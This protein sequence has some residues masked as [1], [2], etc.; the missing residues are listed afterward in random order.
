MAEFEVVRS[1]SIEAPPTRIHGLIADLRAW[2]S[3][4]PWE[5]H[6]P[7]LRRS[8]SGAESGVGAR[9]AWE[10]NRRAG[11]GSMEI[12]ADEPERVALRLTFEKPWKATNDVDF[13]LRP[14]GD[15]ATDVSWRMRGENRGVAAVFA[16]AM[17]M[18]RLVGRDFEK[19]LERLKAAAEGG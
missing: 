8:Y 16:R 6:D 17:S 13:T 11:K 12:V 14:A 3:W 15:G 9:Y 2:R 1:R 18:D 7:E 5:D 19:G 10:G 4:S